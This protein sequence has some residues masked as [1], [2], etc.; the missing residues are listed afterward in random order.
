MGYDR[1]VVLCMTTDAE[2]KF[3]KLIKNSKV[4]TTTDAY[5]D[6][7][8][9]VEQAEK[10]TDTS[11]NESLYHWPVVKWYNGDRFTP[12]RAHILV[13]EMVIRSLPSDQFKFIVLGGDLSDTT[14]VGTYAS[15][16][17][18]PEIIRKIGFNT[19][20]WVKK[21]EGENHGISQ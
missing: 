6:M 4:F 21:I 2:K 20:S 13:L 14:I 17:F 10:Y 11:K 5:T 16:T 8:T 19:P 12:E 18:S 3:S 7:V 1:N 9:L 15:E